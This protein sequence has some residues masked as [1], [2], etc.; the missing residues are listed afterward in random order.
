MA[1]PGSLHRGLRGAAQ[2]IRL[3][4]VVPL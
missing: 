2:A 4:G 3:R 1:L